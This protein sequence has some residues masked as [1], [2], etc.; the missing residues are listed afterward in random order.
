M[1]LKTC[2]SWSNAPVYQNDH[3]NVVNMGHQL[4]CILFSACGSGV[5]SHGSLCL[6]PPNTKEHITVDLEDKENEDVDNNEE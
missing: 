2:L 5:C 4:A 3:I 6:P 1:L